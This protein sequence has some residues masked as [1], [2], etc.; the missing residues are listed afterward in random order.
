[1][2]D[3]CFGGGIEEFSEQEVAQTA[4]ER[5]IDSRL[6]AIESTQR[7]LAR[8]LSEIHCDLHIVLNRKV[9]QKVKP[10]RSEVSIWQIKDAVARR[11]NLINGIPLKNNSQV[12]ALPRHIAMYLSRELIGASFPDIGRAFGKH[13]TTVLSACRN[14]KEME[15][16]DMKIRQLLTA[17]RQELKSAWQK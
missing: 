14:V 6:G 7:M 13:H 5:N 9:A 11:F 15:G 16:K 8:R 17:L 3:E 4:V 10:L 12:Y 2:C 1:M